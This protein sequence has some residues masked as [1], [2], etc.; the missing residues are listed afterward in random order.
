MFVVGGPLVSWFIV[1][2]PWHRSTLVLTVI[3]LTVGAWSVVLAWPG[4]APLPVLVVLAVVVGMGSPTSTVG[5]D[6]ARSFAP[7]AQLGVSMAIVNVGGF[8]SALLTV[9]AV[10]ALL[11]QLGHGPGS[12]PAGA[13]YPVAL[14]V[15][16]VGWGLGTWQVLR[17]RR[18]LRR[19]GQEDGRT[20]PADGRVALRRR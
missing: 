4:A 7:T 2:H 14:S 5:F 16:Y 10:G 9:L 18:R 15:Q 20:A 19:A 11:D 6:Y 17:L 3:A 13:A 12:M 1:R 8:L